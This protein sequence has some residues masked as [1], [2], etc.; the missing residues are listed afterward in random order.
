MDKKECSQCKITK[1]K[2]AFLSEATGR[3]FKQCDRCRGLK[4]KNI[5]KCDHGRQKNVCSDC[6]GA[7]ICEHGRR[8]YRCT[9]C[10]G[11]GICEHKRER[12]R[13]RECNGSQI[14]DHGRRKEQ[15]KDCDGN[16]ICEHNK[17]RYFCKICSN[18][19]KITIKRM[20]RQSKTNDIKKGRYDANNFI[21]KC[22]IEMLMDES[23]NCHY[24]KKEM[25]LIEFNDDLCTIER[26]DNSIGHIKSNCV[27]ACRKCNSKH[28]SSDI[29]S[30]K[31]LL[32]KISNRRDTSDMLLFC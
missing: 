15:C 28:K 11:N 16:G 22:F 32:P 6:G 21:D 3:E 24:C 29:F 9:N 30:K 20:L 27:L 1:D 8:K 18:P 10:N 14:C 7:S 2:K 13:C 26:L 5:K 25:Q 17:H 19:T 4:R 31:Y 23:M 12:A